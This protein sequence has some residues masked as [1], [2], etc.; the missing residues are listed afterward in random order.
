MKKLKMFAADMTI[1]AKYLPVLI[2]LMVLSVIF[3]SMF[4][5]TSADM[6]LMAQPSVLIQQISSG[7]KVFLVSALAVFFMYHAW[8]WYSALRKSS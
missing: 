4:L 2:L 1:V 8:S 6:G 3:T 7:S 5:A